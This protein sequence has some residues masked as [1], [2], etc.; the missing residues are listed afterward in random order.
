MV[1]SNYMERSPQEESN[2]YNEDAET[3]L[4]GLE[5]AE[6]VVSE[7]NN[8]TKRDA[9]DTASQ[10]KGFDLLNVE[11]YKLSDKYG[12]RNRRFDD[13]RRELINVLRETD[14][15]DYSSAESRK[16]LL[17]AAIERAETPRTVEE[18]K[19]VMDDYIEELFDVSNLDYS[20]QQRNQ[21]VDFL[22]H[23][24]Y[25]N[26][27]K[28]DIRMDFDQ[29]VVEWIRRGVFSDQIKKTEVYEPQEAESRKKA[30]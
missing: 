19:T 9:S 27:S 20:D 16:K 10:A 21:M 6:T 1:L 11:L 28:A 29:R 4:I 5:E 23:D 24:E 14:Q 8:G 12:S 26:R 15:V 17:D 30:A 22:K 13:I 2:N 7:V 18:M 3:V 25:W